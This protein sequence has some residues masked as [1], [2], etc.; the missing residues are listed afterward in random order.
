A[1]FAEIRVSA[2][3]APPLG[4]PL[5]LAVADE[6]DDR[7]RLTIRHTSTPVARRSA[8]R[9]KDASR[10][11]R[12][13]ASDVVA[14]MNTLECTNLDRRR[15]RAD[16]HTV[17][18]GKAGRRVDEGGRSQSLRPASEEQLIHAPVGA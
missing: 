13:V 10:R 17:A 14:G 5:R 7:R 15:A 3:L 18:Q 4:I 8:A 6:V 11:T 1:L 12:S 16:G 9:A 2:A